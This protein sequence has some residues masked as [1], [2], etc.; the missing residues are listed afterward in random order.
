MEERPIASVVSI[1]HILLYDFRVT[2]PLV[3]IAGNKTEKHMERSIS[4]NA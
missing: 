1:A 2:T 3:I 4:S